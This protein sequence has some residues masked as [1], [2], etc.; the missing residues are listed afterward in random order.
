MITLNAIKIKNFRSFYTEQTLTLSSSKKSNV[1]AIFGP[2]SGGKSNTAK[3]LSYIGNY[4]TNSSDAN[5]IPPYDPFL[6]RDTSE[7]EPTCFTLFFEHRKRHYEYGFCYT[8]TQVTSEY[9]KERT[10]KTGKSKL[11][12][13]RDSEGELNDAAH[14]N[15]FGKTILKATRKETLLITKARENNNEYS[16]IV[17]DL[18]NSLGIFL[19]DV[20]DQTNIFIELLKQ[21]SSLRERA[22][23]LLK[24]CDLSIRGF[25]FE[26]V[27]IPSDVIAALPL[28]DDVKQTFSTGTITKTIHAVRNAENDIVGKREF[29]FWNQESMGTRKFLDLIV[30]IIDALDTGKTIYIDE[31]GAYIHP[32]LANAIIRLFKSDRNTNGAKLVINTHNI[33]LMSDAGLSREEIIFIEKTLAEE[34]VIRSLSDMSVR[35]DEA[36]EKRYR[37]GLYGGVPMLWSEDA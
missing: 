20:P 17:F 37:S 29:D 22:V 15:G 34:S 24:E 16:N 5:F 3:A 19:G 14:R 25:E 1:T 26:D 32:N 27:A 33:S 30:P 21:N 7:S 9:L 4:I 36:I 10:T 35:K 6:L 2:N 13:S 31:F 18:L 11:I 12:F 28:P 23:E 8:H